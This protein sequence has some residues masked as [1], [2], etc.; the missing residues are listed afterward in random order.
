MFEGTR[1]IPIK[2]F[3]SLFEFL[4]CIFDESSRNGVKLE[5]IDGNGNMDSR[6]FIH[7]ISI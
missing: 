3:E 5:A 4:P 2:I 7:K 6:L 1:H